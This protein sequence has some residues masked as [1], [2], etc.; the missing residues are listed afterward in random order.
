MLDKRFQKELKSILFFALEYGMKHTNMKYTKFDNKDFIIKVHEG[1]MKAQKLIIQHLLILGKA[2]NKEKVKLKEAR[3]NKNKELV[4]TIELKL[5][6]IEY[7]EN[8]LR[9]VADSI[10]WIILQEDS[11]KI[12]RLFLD[13]PQVEIY[14][15]NLNHDLKFI[16][17]IFN[18]NNLNFALLTDITS[19]IQISDVL[20]VDIIEKKIKFIELKEGSIND[21]ISNVLLNLTE[22]KCEFALY[23]QLKDKDEKYL[24]QLNRVVKQIDKS[25]KVLNTINAGEGVD[26]ATGF[27]ITIS[28]GIFEPKYYELIIRDMLNEVNKKNYSLR[29]IDDCLIIGVYNSKAIPIQ[30]GFNSWKKKC[31]ID[32]PTVDIRIFL[33]SPVAR[34]FFLNNFSIEDKVDV[35]SGNK[36]ILMAL[37]FNK[38][39]EILESEGI[40]VELLSQKVTR[41][42]NT[43]PSP[44]RVFEYN[45]QAI[46]IKY[47]GFEEI[48]AGGLFEKMF[49]QFFKPTSVIEFIKFRSKVS[50]KRGQ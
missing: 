32:F 49:N 40:E 39:I 37:D 25:N 8:I 21:D 17:E 30:T 13:S 18:E 11:T 15:S 38:W 24:K 12:K 48:L 2:K 43:V 45:G 23:Q 50:D 5:N 29:T 34:P 31:G 42:Y 26:Y 16:E 1:Y 47:N 14:N 22:T 20:L 41:R 7:K 4:S 35:L 27:K 44:Q 6:N 28:E 9:K 36:H 3:R 10:A 46:K 33:K 19:F